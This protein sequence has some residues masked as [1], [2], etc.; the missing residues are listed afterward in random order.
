MNPQS[1]STSPTPSRKPTSRR[2]QIGFDGILAG[3]IGAVT[4][5]LWFLIIDLIGGKPLYTPSILAK[6]FLGTVGTSPASPDLQR[7]FEIVWSY[8]WWHGLVFVALGSGISWLLGVSEQNPK[9][10]FGV[11][12]LMT[13]LFVVV[14]GVVAIYSTQ[15]LH[16]LSWPVIMIGNVLAAIAM[17]IYFWRRHRHLRINLG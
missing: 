10:G 9:M 4:L 14:T 1:I 3:V 5:A 11:M 12:L 16:V 6:L 17:S 2:A 15:V 8:T 7:S 13:L